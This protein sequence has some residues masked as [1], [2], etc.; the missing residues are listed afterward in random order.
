MATGTQRPSRVGMALSLACLLLGCAHT[1]EFGPQARCVL[2]EQVSTAALVAHVNQNV[3]RVQSWRTLNAEISSPDLPFRVAA[4]V[5]VEAPRNFRLVV[6]SPLGPEVDLGSNQQHYWFWSRQD[7][8]K[9]IYLASHE[10]DSAAQPPSGM[11][12]QPEWIMEAMGVIALDPAR[13]QEVS[14][15]PQARTVTVAEDRLSPQGDPVRKLTVVDLCHGLV[16]EHALV[17]AQGALI[18]RAQLLDPVR[19]KASGGVIPSRIHMIWPQARI[20]MTMALRSVEVNTPISRST[21]TM[22]QYKGC[23]V[24]QVGGD[25]GLPNGTFGSTTGP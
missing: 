9:R 15:D 8:S 18:A 22:Q 17:D 1:Q 5:A 11:P 13:V 20:D 24:F 7:E 3:A 12:F 4:S 21:F 2:P 10:S 14:R 6:R 16:R 25:Q 19:D 23:E